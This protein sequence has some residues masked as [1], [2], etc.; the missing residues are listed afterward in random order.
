M[1]ERKIYSP[2][3]LVGYVSDE[4]KKFLRAKGYNGKIIL[5]AWEFLSALVGP[6]TLERTTTHVCVQAFGAHPR[7][8]DLKVVFQVSDDG[9]TVSQPMSAHPYH[10]LPIYD[11][12]EMLFERLMQAAVK[13]E[14]DALSEGNK[15]EVVRTSPMAEYPVVREIRDAWAAR[16]EETG[17]EFALRWELEEE[18]YSMTLL[19]GQPKEL[20]Y[21]VVASSLSG[22]PSVEKMWH[23]RLRENGEVGDCACCN[24]GGDPV[25]GRKLEEIVAS[26][27]STIWGRCRK[28]SNRRNT[29]WHG[30][31]PD[32]EVEKPGS[33]RVRL[34]KIEEAKSCGT[35]GGS[36]IVYRLK[37]MPEGYSTT[38]PVPCAECEKRKATPPP[39]PQITKTSEVAP[40]L[41]A[42]FPQFD[43]R[44]A[45]YAAKEARGF[46]G[47]FGGDK[48]RLSAHWV[49]EKDGI[50]NFN[51]TVC[52]GKRLS[53]TI[54][55][56]QKT[57]GNRFNGVNFR[58]LTVGLL[59]KMVSSIL[60][61]H[62]EMSVRHQAD[63]ELL[64][65]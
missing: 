17:E 19:R 33:W 43:W 5:A 13:A 16:C 22:E 49:E 56:V 14:V 9:K 35:C 23:I 46:E 2:G 52:L 54:W 26:L 55:E 15:P 18:K 58:S 12:F 44:E 21:K 59:R 38:E 45:K 27:H 3:Q 63:I 37:W 11:G 60:S 24:V 29:P 7:V 61:E 47:I 8:P 40:M 30:V 1:Q 62:R 25:V 41:M 48:L 4:W 64:P 50:N 39:P 32:K 10:V 65:L 28:T 34:R 31:K 57:R 42:A 51:L 53:R 20:V 6:P 36:G